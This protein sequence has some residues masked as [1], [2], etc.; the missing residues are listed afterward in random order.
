MKNYC[1]FQVAHP[2]CDR[3]MILARQDAVA[4]IAEYMRSGTTTS[5]NA[6]HNFDGRDSDME[7]VHLPEISS[8]LSSALT[9]LSKS[10]DIERGITRIFYRTAT[11][12]E[13]IDFHY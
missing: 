2:L 12:S 11:A 3:N 7:T 6:N 4:E 9:I 10:I 13:V 1:T 8:L 5:S